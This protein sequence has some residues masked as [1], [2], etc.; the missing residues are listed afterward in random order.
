MLS[1]TFLGQTATG[2]YALGA[3]IVSSLMLLPQSVSRVLYPKVS[4]ALGLGANASDCFQ[5]VI[6][7]TRMMNL[8]L[9]FGVGVMMLLAPV[10]YKQILPKYGPGLISA[11]VLLAGCFCRLT[12]ANGANYLIASN[13]Q[14]SLLRHI[15]ISLLVG[16]G[17][18][19]IAIRMECGIVGIALSAGISGTALAF[20][21]WRTVFRAFGYR[22]GELYWQMCDLYLPFVLFMVLMAISWTFIPG[23]LEYG[24]LSGVMHVVIFVCMLGGICVAIPKIRNDVEGWIKLLR[25]DKRLSVGTSVTG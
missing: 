5:L 25:I 20:L 15:C 16:V 18:A 17:V 11:Q 1:I 6:F 24:G 13:R 2:Y 8:M 23:F 14:S 4:N 9:P 10:V 3:A 7:P 19:L 12:L 22:G 21:V